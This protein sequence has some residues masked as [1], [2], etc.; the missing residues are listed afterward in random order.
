M[1]T[2]TC[3]KDKKAVAE[4]YRRGLSLSQVA[5]KHHVS[6][7]TIRRFFHENGI[8]VRTASEGRRSYSFDE[9]AF[10]VISEESAYWAGVMMADG[11]VSYSKKEVHA[12]L[13]HL[14]FKRSDEGHLLKFKVFLKSNHPI[15]HKMSRHKI[16]NPEKKHPFSSVSIRSHRLAQ[17]LAKLGV[18]PGKTF[19]TEARSGLENDRHFWRGVVDGDGCISS[20]KSHNGK[21]DYPQLF[22]LGSKRLMD[23]FVSFVGRIVDT[24]SVPRKVK[25]ARIFR[26]HLTCS[27]AASVIRHLYENSTI[28]LDRKYVRADAIML[29]MEQAA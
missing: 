7:E 10:N 5:K 29:K 3:V 9:T 19:R 21:L 27:K 18:V 22:A 6:D 1:Y 25:N 26:V 4:D 13:V 17:A 24:E 28:S 23:Q 20:F 8:R 14:G 11:S 16:H 2:F 15:F 12:P